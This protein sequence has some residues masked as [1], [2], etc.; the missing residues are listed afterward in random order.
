M[1]G[2]YVMAAVTFL[3]TAF[4]CVATLN[5]LTQSDRRYYWLIV[6]GLPLSLIV[7]RFIK[8]PVIAA[9]AAWT[10]IPLRIGLDV[11]P[12]FI[13]AVWLNAPIFEEA[14]KLLP[15]ILPASRGFLRDAPRSL[16]AGLALGMGFGLGEAAYL[17]SGIAQ[18]PDYNQ[19]PWHM[20]TGYA[21]ERL[22]VTF[23]HGF[24]TSIAVAGLYYGRS[25]AMSGYLTAVG[26]HALINLGAVLLALNVIPVAVS[27]LGIY[28]TILLAYILFQRNVHSVKVLSGTTPKEIIYF[29]R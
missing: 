6:A 14:I 5:H 23:A 25:K 3:G 24:M 10:G 2:I 19:L 1:P 17:A 4:L 12:R 16:W 22:I 26:L 27:S 21:S 8:T 7:N 13:I 15:M 29:E 9:I 11:P 18:S 20:F 28:A